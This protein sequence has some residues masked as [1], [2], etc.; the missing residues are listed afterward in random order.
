MESTF[1]NKNNST[2]K[3]ICPNNEIIRA[4]GKTMTM[5]DAAKAIIA[6]TAPTDINFEA[7]NAAARTTAPAADNKIERQVILAT[8]T[9]I[10]P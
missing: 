5:I 10:P 2:A 9:R 4:K 1:L 7:I 3:G 6:N 8:V